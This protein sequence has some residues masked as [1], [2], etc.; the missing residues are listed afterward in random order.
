MLISPQIIHV[1][2]CFL[3]KNLC[4]RQWNFGVYQIVTKFF[5]HKW[6]FG[7]EKKNIVEWLI[8]VKGPKQINKIYAIT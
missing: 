1:I 3:H 7:F 6:N 2:I 8:H 4:T 5:I